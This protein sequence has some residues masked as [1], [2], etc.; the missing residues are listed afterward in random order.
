[1]LISNITEKETLKENPILEGYTFLGSK[2]R[3]FFCTVSYDNVF[4]FFLSESDDMLSHDKL[5]INFSCYDFGTAECNS[6][7][8]ILKAFEEKSENFE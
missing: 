8:D 3:V 6:L 5:A 4:D 7:L 1:M 2:D